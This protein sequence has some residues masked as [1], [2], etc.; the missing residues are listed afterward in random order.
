MPKAWITASTYK[1]FNA[2]YDCSVIVSYHTGQV[3]PVFVWACMQGFSSICSH[4]EQ[5]NQTDST[6]TCELVTSAESP[7]GDNSP[8]KTCSMMLRMSMSMSP[9]CC[10]ACGNLAWGTGC[11]SNIV[12]SRNICLHLCRCK[13]DCSICNCC[14]VCCTTEMRRHTCQDKQSKTPLPK[15]GLEHS[16]A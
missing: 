14:T 13:R 10:L 8:S 4:H 6:E 3:L 1:Q 7:E 12:Q 11:Q 2:E 16:S 9:F 15:T 5:K